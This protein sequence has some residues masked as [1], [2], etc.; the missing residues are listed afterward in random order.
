VAAE[1]PFVPRADFIENAF[2]RRFQGL[3]V[4]RIQWRV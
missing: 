1:H 4:A 2:E 3:G